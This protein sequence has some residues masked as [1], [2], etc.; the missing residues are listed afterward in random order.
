MQCNH[1]LLPKST[2]VLWRVLTQMHKVNY[3]TC[4][5]HWENPVYDCCAYVHL[6]NFNLL[7]IS[8]EIF[9]IFVLNIPNTIFKLEHLQLD[10]Y[11][12]TREF[13]GNSIFISLI[14][15]VWNTISVYVARA[16]ACKTRFFFVLLKK[17]AD[18]CF[19]NNLRKLDF[20]VEMS[21][22]KYLVVNKST[23]DQQSYLDSKYN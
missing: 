10:I 8:S 19:I 18:F 3:C 5:A 9:Y 4:A 22:L 15:L 17:S 1:L 23:N 6:C 12:L 7:T 21:S 11:W 14:V 13:I 2:F 20:V 16:I